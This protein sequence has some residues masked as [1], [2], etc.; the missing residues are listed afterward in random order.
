MSPAEVMWRVRGKIR[1]ATDRAVLASRQDVVP[2]SRIVRKGVPEELVDGSM[3]GGHWSPPGQ[4]DSLPRAWRDA[5]VK[6]ADRITD[7]KLSFFDLE[8][9]DL[10]AEIDWNYEHKAKKSTPT[11]FA[12]AIDYRDHAET[13]DCK[14]A[15]EPSR[16]HQLVV[17]GR[18]YRVTGDERYARAVLDQIESWMRQCPFG[19]GMQWRSPLE[20]GIRLINWAWALELIAPSRLFINRRQEQIIAVAWRHIWE[21]TRKYSQYS[22]AN[23]HLIGEAAAVYIGCSYFT[24]L[25]DASRWRRTARDILVREIFEQTYDDGGTREQ[26]FDYH[27]FVLQFFLAA[28]LA[29]RNS[30]DEF[31]CEFWLRLEKMCECVSALVQGGDQPPMFGDADDGYVLDLGGERSD[32]RSLLTVGAAIFRRSD[33]KAASRGYHEWAYWLLGDDGKKAYDDTA[34]SASDHTLRSRALPDSGYYLLQNGVAGEADSISVLFDCGELGFKS[35]AAHGHADA[36][37]VTLRL[38]GVDVLVD[39]GTYDYFTYGPWRKYFRSTSAHNTALVDGQDQSEMQGL[40][41][42]GSKAN[43]KLLDWQPTP[44]GGTVC[45]EHDG[46]QR[47]SDP[48]THRRKVALTGE[49]ATVEIVDDFIADGPHEIV[50]HFHF[51]ENC[52]LKKECDEHWTLD[53]GAGKAT[54]QLDA[55]FEFRVAEGSEAPIAGWISRGY[56]RKTSTTTLIARCTCVGRVTFV[57]RLVAGSRKSVSRERNA[58]KASCAGG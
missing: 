57:T 2:L 15:W 44:T 21:I 14:F 46:Y 18:A 34:V 29:G 26:A 25:K 12:G 54:L 23:N 31:P 8:D 20:I 53:Y 4:L 51:G 19:T 55:R 35:I 50:L 39:P 27:L 28:G 42:W 17:L 58:S 49:S 22:S 37:S 48:V 24:C 30:G 38:G 40:F 9:V 5:V 43:T 56:H 3:F 33:F 1:D 6:Q 13:G 36:L 41:L 11:G 10:G 16:H 45:G 47:L 52:S 7:H 32:P